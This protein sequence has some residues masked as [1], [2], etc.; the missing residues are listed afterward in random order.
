M[1]VCQMG[2]FQLKELHIHL[3][4]FQLAGGIPPEIGNL[5]NFTRI[6]FKQ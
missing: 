4:N 3:N 6:N 2:V 5:T 1:G